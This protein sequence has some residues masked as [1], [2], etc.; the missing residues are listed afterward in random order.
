MILFSDTIRT[1]E[2]PLFTPRHDKP[3]L[4]EPR[5]TLLDYL[6]RVS[7]T[8]RRGD[9]REES[10]YPCLLELLTR[11]AKLRGR[12]GVH[13]TMV[14]KKAGDCL[15]DFQ[16]WHGGR[17]VGYVEAKRPGTDLDLAAGSKQLLRYRATFPN[18]L[19][20]NFRELRLYRGDDLAGRADTLRSLPG[21]EPVLDLIDLFLGFSPPPAANAAALARQLAERTRILAGRIHDL[22]AADR[23]GA[24]DLAGFHKAFCE[25]LLAG[26]TFRE[27][28][29]L[30][31][32]TI[33][34]GLLT[35]RWRTP[36]GGAFDRRAA[37][38]HIPRANGIL[39]DAFQFISLGKP[40]GEIG[41]I[42]DDVIALLASASVRE[43]LERSGRAQGG[44]PIL[45]FYETF[46]AVYD[47]T[48]RKKRGVYYTPRA[49]VSYVVRSVHRL[50]ESPLGRPHGL[51]NPE[52]TLL[53]PAAGTLTFL[54]E[55]IRCAMETARAEMG[56]GSVP[57]L[58]RDHLL[59]DFHAFELMM[60]PYAMGHLQVSLILEEIGH[61]LGTDERFPL[62]LTNALVREELE[63]TPIPGAAAL[64]RESHD[65]ARVKNEQPILVVL[66]N[67]PWSGHSANRG[68]KVDALIREPYT[69]A[70]GERRPGYLTVDGGP[71]GEKNPKWLQ[72]DYV[73]FLRFAQWKIDQ[74]GEGIVAFVTNHGWLDNPTFRG[75]RR[76][77]LETFDEIRV[78]DLHGNAKKRERAPDGTADANVFEDVMQGAAVA[79]LVKKPGLA[80]KVFRADL[81]GS[82]REKLGWLTSH[83]VRTTPWAEAAPEGPGYL[84]APRDT[85]LAKEYG[86]GVPL[87][88]IFPVHSAGVV[89]GRDAFVIDRD[90]GEL[91][92]RIVQLRS[93]REE[94]LFQH[95]LRDTG[96]WKL[97]EAWRRARADERWDERFADVL[98]R[99]F[100][101]RFLFYADYLIERPRRRVMEPLLAGRNLGLVVPRQSG[102]EPAALVTDTLAAHKAVSAYDVNTLFPLYLLEL[103]ERVPNVA[104]DLLG[105]LARDFGEEVHPV[106]ILNYVYAVLWGGAWRSRYA[107][108]LREGFPR[109]PFPRDAG[110]FLELAG[111]GAVLVDLH[112]LRS[113]RLARPAVRFEGEGSGKPARSRQKVRE[114][115]PAEHRVVVNEEGQSF[116]GIAPEA[117]ACRIGGYPVLDHWLAD[118]AGCALRY[119][120]IERFRK[121]ATALAITVEVRRRIDEAWMGV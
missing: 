9:A 85:A 104:P 5:A 80:K 60:A 45:H 21:E 31:A 13:V 64:S 27:F 52:V 66:G 46:L 30:Y 113:D 10:F 2:V 43:I 7:E 108:F 98:Y 4:P 14:P 61:P 114:Y 41:W 77:L 25:Y 17:I 97:A 37:A 112:L 15:L 16:V 50:L 82:R 69:V 51:A 96:T 26:L 99:P 107:A 118:R 38:E 111:L 121:T 20:T 53:D 11:C 67:P 79:F 29:D 57:P 88:E 71:L 47:G 94:D 3:L 119:D 120:E 90:L 58:L 100:D 28:A 70:G 86:R 18:L 72:D 115:L 39:H 101:S 55:A 92:R 8:E 22:L 89:T 12:R 93:R 42:V 56:G 63:Q 68:R 33:A 40:P 110:P 59:R 6:E 49:V 109:I 36:E 54:V 91:R 83:D 65:A 1:V 87:S 95:G 44:D 81:W 103:G 75:L 35:A 24:S 32:Q 76:S 102:E 78:L 48:L 23:E 62:Y 74:A 84:F 73:K 116:S 105:R 106:E 34:Y 19:L 117:W